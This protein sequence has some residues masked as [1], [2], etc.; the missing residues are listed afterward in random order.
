MYVGAQ[1]H[2]MCVKIRGQLAGV[3]SLLPTSRSW[4]VKSG[5]QALR[6][7]PVP[8]KPVVL[9]LWV[10]TPLTDIYITIQNSTKMIVLR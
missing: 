3:G 10:T 2:S 6:Q 4:A 8:R 1:C 7:M 5:L 9:S